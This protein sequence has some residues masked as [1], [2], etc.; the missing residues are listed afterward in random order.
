M[1][2]NYAT[3]MLHLTHIDVARNLSSGA[4]MQWR[5]SRR[6]STRSLT[7]RAPCLKQAPPKRE[8]FCLIRSFPTTP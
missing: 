6:R 3:C 5:I 1:N 2:L 4:L 8:N 7:T